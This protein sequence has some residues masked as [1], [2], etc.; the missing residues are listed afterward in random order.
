MSHRSC[1]CWETPALDSVVL[2]LLAQYDHVKTGAA[3]YYNLL[4]VRR[5]WTTLDGV[6]FPMVLIATTV[7][8]YRSHTMSCREGEGILH[9]V[10]VMPHCDITSS[11]ETLSV[12]V[13][14]YVIGSSR[15]E[16]GALQLM[17][18][19]LTMREPTAGRVPRTDRECVWMCYFCCDSIRGTCMQSLQIN[20]F[21]TYIYRWW[22]SWLQYGIVK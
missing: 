8:S 10:F 13:T 15:T 11:E 1:T 4:V 12:T 3:I 19:P 22:L 9:E 17:V 2:D 7:T 6:P 18:N 5:L 14:Q 16:N 21:G 20:P